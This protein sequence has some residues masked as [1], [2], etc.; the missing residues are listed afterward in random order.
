MRSCACR[1]S[2]RTSVAF[3]VSAL[4]LTACGGTIAQT[5]I[6]ARAVE[7]RACESKPPGERLACVRQMTP[8]RE[9]EPSGGACVGH[10]DGTAWAKEAAPNCVSRAITG[11]QVCGSIDREERHASNVRRALV[12]MKTAAPDERDLG[13]IA[14]EMRELEAALGTDRCA[15]DLKA[16]SDA[17]ECLRTWQAGYGNVHGASKS[18]FV[19]VE[20]RRAS[21]LERAAAITQ[22]RVERERILAEGKSAIAAARAQEA[23]QKRVMDAR[24]TIRVSVE[25]C[26]RGWLET[27][28]HC[29]DAQLV[30]GERK[31]CADACRSAAHEGVDKTFSLAADA[32]VQ[33]FAGSAAALPGECVLRANATGFLSQDEV[34]KRR[35][36]C[37]S[38]CRRRGPAARAQVVSERARQ[39]AE[40]RKE[41]EQQRRE[42][43]EERAAARRRPPPSAT[44]KASPAADA[45]LRVFHACAPLCRSAAVGQGK[46]LCLESCFSQSGSSLR[47]CEPFVGDIPF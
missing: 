18:C 25:E 33:S 38:D 29:D 32:C 45:C 22:S 24:R 26:G 43:A 1:S 5:A 28:P 17:A 8:L 9:D 20:T 31:E 15:A 13:H 23:E 35:A 44:K 42:E 6:D 40:R 10:V 27:N 16:L 46:L 4:I 34:R 3:T 11:D 7:Q 39:Q 21:V 37:T 36:A 14:D 41:E 30:A 12:E 47:P 19:E 2:S